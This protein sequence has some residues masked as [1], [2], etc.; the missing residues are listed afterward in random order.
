MKLIELSKKFLRCQEN[1]DWDSFDKLLAE[2]V[3]LELTWLET[4]I[5]GKENMKKLFKKTCMVDSK[6]E[7]D[8]IIGNE[9]H[10]VVTGISSRKE[11]IF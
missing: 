7:I 8:Q 11:G 6:F 9:E 10:V 2:N 3:K 1:T 5:E 4:T